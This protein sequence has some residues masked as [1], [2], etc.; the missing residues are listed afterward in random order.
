MLRKISILLACAM[1]VGCSLDTLP[2]IT[3][4]QGDML[5]PPRPGVAAMFRGLMVPVPGGRVNASGGNLFLSRRDMSVGTR[6]Q[7]WVVGASWNS[8]TG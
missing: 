7:E 3:N 4:I 2:S 1:G 6:V 8:A 5:P